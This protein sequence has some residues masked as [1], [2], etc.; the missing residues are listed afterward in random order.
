MKKAKPLVR[1]Q[2]KPAAAGAAKVAAPHKLLSQALQRLGKARICTPQA[3]PVAEMKRNYPLMPASPQ[4][5]DF[6]TVK[7]ARAAKPQPQPQPAAQRVSTPQGLAKG[8]RMLPSGRKRR[9]ASERKRRIVRLNILRQCSK[10][11]AATGTEYINSLVYNDRVHIVTV[12]KDYL[13]FDETKEVLTSYCNLEESRTKL[14]TFTRVARQQYEPWIPALKE[15]RFLDKAREKKEKIRK[16]KE[17]DKPGS[18][19]GSTFLRTA[20]MNSL[21]KEDL[22]NSLSRLP[23]NSLDCSKEEDCT[24]IVHLLAALNDRDG[25]LVRKVESPPVNTNAKRPASSEPLAAASKKS[26]DTKS[27]SP[28][29]PVQPSQPRCQ[30]RISTVSKNAVRLLTQMKGVSPQKKP[31][32]P[33]PAK[34]TPFQAYLTQL[35]PKPGATL[36]ASCTNTL[37]SALALGKG[38]LS[39]DAKTIANKPGVKA[40][41]RK[42]IMSTAK[43]PVLISKT[44]TV[45]Q[46]KG[47]AKPCTK[48]STSI[49]KYGG[50]E[51]GSGKQ[52][53]FAGAHQVYSAVKYSS[54][55]PVQSKMVH[56]NTKTVASIVKSQEKKGSPAKRPALA[57]NAGKSGKLVMS[58]A[59]AKTKAPSI[60]TKQQ[61]AAEGSLSAR[62]ANPKVGTKHTRPPA[63]HVEML[64]RPNV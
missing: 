40:E 46:R 55:R 2:K 26:G 13:V 6:G 63:K 24:R 45:D 59:K 1:R 52:Q 15:H 29:K 16:I 48:A 4:G 34:K 56:Q 21:A 11:A 23:A 22:S 8:V 27:H 32:V 33:P 37:D 49:G 14:R 62:G 38:I 20:F 17:A 31:T 57:T 12:F 30:T 35:H 7:S 18:E 36:I 64:R 60:V 44:K 5:R 43:K 53:P 41:T 50:T 39:F 10:M 58:T 9:S 3:P 47:T 42:V 54:N 25:S 51:L 61:P 28:A 19:D